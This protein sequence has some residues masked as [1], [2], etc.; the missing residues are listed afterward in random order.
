MRIAVFADNHGN[1]YATKAVL[2]AISESGGYD[3]VFIT[4]A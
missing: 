1:P 3:S 2:D 4:G